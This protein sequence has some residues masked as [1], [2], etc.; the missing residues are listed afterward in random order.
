MPIQISLV[1]GT[2]VS[3]LVPVLAPAAV[4]AAVLI[5]GMPAY[6]TLFA[7]SSAMLSEAAYQ[8]EV[9]Q[10]LAFGLSN[11][12]WAG[13]QT[14]GAAAAGGLAQA[15]SDIVPFALLAGVCLGT[16]VALRWRATRYRAA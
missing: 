16:L 6:G 3:V 11:L 8:L 14:V 12:A 2:V 13:G 5:V 7:P 10:G 1:V 9:N 15:T 4:L